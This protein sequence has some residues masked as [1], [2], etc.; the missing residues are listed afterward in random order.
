MVIREEMILMSRYRSWIGLPDHEMV[1]G[2]GMVAE[3]LFRTSV[4]T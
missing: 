3:K 2:L 4:K 1:R